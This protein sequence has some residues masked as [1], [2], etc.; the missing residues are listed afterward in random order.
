M[1]L[2]RRRGET[3]ATG[4]LLDPLASLPGKLTTALQFASVATALVV[5]SWVAPLFVLTAIAGIGPAIGYWARE[6]DYRAA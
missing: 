3:T 5:G 2:A 1:A 4:A 6:L